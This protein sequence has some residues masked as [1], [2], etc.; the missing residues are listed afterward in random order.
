MNRVRTVS[1]S[2]VPDSA[3]GVSDTTAAGLHETGDYREEYGRLIR[4]LAEAE[5]ALQALAAGEIDA[6]VDPATTT[7]ILLSRAQ[8]ALKRSEA[9]Y[10]DLVARSPA[11]VCELAP[12]GTTL[13]VNAAA[14]T[15]LGVEPESVR[16]RNW[17]TELVAE[18]GRADAA[19]LAALLA[20]RDVTGVELPFATQSGEVRWIALTSVNRYDDTRALGSVVLFGID[21]TE[22][23]IAA[24]GAQR[25]AAEQVARAEAE[26]ASLAKSEFLATM[27]H[28]LRTP[29]NAIG[30]YAQLLELGVAGPLTEPQLKNLQRI[31]ASGQHLLGLIN[32]V[33][34]LA[35]VEAGRLTVQHVRVDAQPLIDTAYTLVAPQAEERGLTIAI[36]CAEGGH[37]M[38]DEDR[39]RQILV[40]LMSNAVKFT[41]AGG[42]VL[43][44][45][46]TT[47]EPDPEARLH[48]GQPWL[49]LRVRDTGIG[50]APEQLAAVFE[51]FVQAESGH[52]RTKGGTGLG[53]TISRRLARLMGGDVTVR[54]TVGGGSVF[55]LWLAVGSQQS[56]L[57]EGAVARSLDLSS[58]PRGLSEAGECL[59]RE[60]ESILEAFASRLRCEPLTARA[61]ELKFSQLANHLGTFIAV[62]A[63]SL[64][65]LDEAEGEPSS[66]MDDG[67]EIQRLV[68]KRHG[69]QRARLGW[70]VEGLS[71]EFAILREEA[72]RAIRRGFVGQEDVRY[73]EA[74][75]ILH[76]LF[77]EAGAV[78][79]QE[80]RRC[81]TG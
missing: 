8:D 21:T 18:V 30:G 59:L 51:P 62:V 58:L 10:R 15:L 11:L 63:D 68:A 22:R 3:G 26:A 47:T 73:E 40:N 45:C 24:E 46:G 74:L 44:E 76:R 32:E 37:F 2:S 66:I 1:K 41:P 7:T 81:A 57:G 77:D 79:V 34:D 42:R 54:S 31:R 43:L 75:T 12:D 13:F 55:T 17:W 69:L 64:T 39:T 6:V 19:S 25:L 5:G 38:G 23:R 49:F 14:R 16:G 52:T 65:A 72:E 78:S 70:T 20:T 53:L 48:R 71:R 56:P 33:L 50:I 60:N 9:R 35:K 4:R 80:L 61:K 28:E 29:L 67:L 36:Q 27:S